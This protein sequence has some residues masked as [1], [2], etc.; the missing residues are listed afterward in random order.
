MT[1]AMM[2]EATISVI[3]RD[4]EEQKALADMILKHNVTQIEDRIMMAGNRKSFTA[5]YRN[6]AFFDNNGATE[7]ALKVVNYF[8]EQGYQ[9]T[10]KGF[11]MEFSW[12][13]K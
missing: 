1:A 9:V 2:R 10:Q 5:S 8:E 13:P 4:L 7:L 11:W 12:K 6:S 3:K